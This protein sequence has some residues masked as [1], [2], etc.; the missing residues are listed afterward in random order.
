MSS[1]GRT[2]PSSLSLGQW[3]VC[4]AMFTGYFSATTAANAA[5]AAEPVT[6]SFTPGPERYSA[7]PVETWMIPSEPASANPL[8]AAFSVWEE[9][10]LIAGKA[11]DPA[12]AASSISA[13]FSG[14]AMG[15]VELLSGASYGE[16]HPRA[17]AGSDKAAAEPS[18]PV[19]GPGVG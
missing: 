19:A 6:M 13:Y 17:S 1:S 14:V 15:M 10:T 11:K 4:S 8:S 16:F 9:D 3:S 2:K 12:F 5:N 7:P 18:Q